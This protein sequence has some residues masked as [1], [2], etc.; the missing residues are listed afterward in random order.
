[1]PPTTTHSIHWDEFHRDSRQLCNRLSAAHSWSRILAIARGG[2]FPAGII[3]RELDIRETHVLCVKSYL[4]ETASG[5][6]SRRDAVQ[7]LS[8]LPAGDGSGW[9]VIDDLADTGATI[10]AIRN[11]LPNA[12]Y[13]AIYTKPQGRSAL[14]HFVQEFPQNCWLN[15][16]WDLEPTYAPP[17][18]A[19]TNAPAE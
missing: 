19:R 15:F 1:M 8:P 12:C 2:L 6:A 5:P 9:L 7:F 10:Q 3:A 17:L 18:A 13:A 16:P 4:G 11:H 14:D